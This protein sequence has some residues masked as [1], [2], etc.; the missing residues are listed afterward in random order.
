MEIVSRGAQIIASLAIHARRFRNF[1]VAKGWRH[2]AVAGAILV[3]ASLATP[4]V[5]EALNLVRLR[6]WLYQELAALAPRALEPHYARVLLIGDDEFWKGAPEGRRPIKRDY[7]AAIVRALDAADVSVIALDF[8]VRLGDPEAQV[9][10]G[11]LEAITPSYRAE[12]EQLMQAIAAAADKRPIVLSKAIWF[13]ERDPD[14]RRFIADIYQPY[15]ICTGFDAKGHWRNPG[16]PPAFVLTPAA[17]RN[18]SCGYIALPYDMRRL[19][20]P[21]EIEGQDST[22]DS[23]SLA[24]AKAHDAD[25]FAAAGARAYYGSYIA[26][27]TLKNAHVT[28]SAG[29][30]LHGNDAVRADLRR[31]LQHKPVIVG[32]DWH[33]TQYGLGSV[34]DIHETPIGWINGAVIHENFVEAMLDGRSYAYVPAWLLDTLEVMFGVAAALVFA[35]YS[36]FR[37]KLLVFAIFTLGLVFIQWLMLQLFGTFFEAFLPLLALWLHSVI[38]RFVGHPSAAAI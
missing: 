26:E 19:P 8:D 1:V 27:A 2:W 32:G 23:F 34:V 28:F 6:Y 7:L 14:A 35:A 38:E 37:V 25:R 9:R 24:I 30:L 13:G 31:E 29:D 33:L 5:D 17:Q 22:L 16:V 36:G 15:G 3:A 11:A 10:P 4:Y 18:I 21:I 20:P 12:T